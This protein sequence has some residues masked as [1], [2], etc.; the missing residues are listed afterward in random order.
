MQL[1][2][3]ELSHI[4]SY[5]SG[6]LELGPGTTLVVGDVG[7]GKTSLLYAIE[8]ALFGV[9]EV[10]ATYLIRHGAARA[11]VAVR[12]EDAE[13][14][15]EVA[16]GFRRV[17]RRGRE[18]FEPER[19]AFLEDGTRTEYSATEIRRRV[20]DLLGFPDNPSPQARSDLWRWA[21][22]VPQEQM[23]AILAARPEDRLE[24]VRKALGV[25]RFRIAADNAELLAHDLK[26]GARHRRD[27]ASQLA[28]WADELQEA[29][30]EVARLTVEKN[31]LEQRREKGAAA[32]EAARARVLALEERARAL[33]GARREAD[34]LDREQEAETRLL[35]RN[36]R[37]R[38]DRTEEL[39]RT[40]QSRDEAL[41]QA[42]DGPRWERELAQAEEE[43]TRRRAA[44]DVHGEELQR[45]AAVRA[46]AEAS[47]RLE[48]E[49]KRTCERRRVDLAEARLAL[50]ASSAEGP[51]R[52]PPAPTPRSLVDI[53]RELGERRA[54]EREGAEGS[55]P[56]RQ[57]L[58][59]VDELL[60]AGVCPTCHQPVDPAAF[61][62]H[63]TEAVRVAEAA[64]RAHLGL[65][66]GLVRLEEERKARERYERAH[67]RWKETERRRTVLREAQTRA[68]DA[69]REA[70]QAEASALAQLR[71]N[72]EAVQAFGSVA[73]DAARLRAELGAA[74]ASSAGLREK[75]ERANASAERA[76]ALETTLQALAAELGRAEQE[77][78]TVEERR[79]ERS[80]RLEAARRELLSSASV[81]QDL[82]AARADALRVEEAF[83][84][85]R[86]ALARTE[87]HLASE[88]R[89]AVTA[90]QGRTRARTLLDEAADLEA[91]A[92]WASGPFRLHVLTMERKVLARAQTVFDREFSRYFATLVDDP[93][94][95][96]RVDAGFTP[97]V[98]IDGDATP[99][100]ALS[101]GERTSLALAFRL[102]LATVVRSL[103]SVRLATLIL[104]EPTDGFSSEQ[105]VRMG[106]LLEELAIPQVIVVSHEAQLASIAD[107]VVRVRKEEGRSVLEADV[108][109]PSRGA[110]AA[111]ANDEGSRGQAVL[112]PR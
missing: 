46:A 102:A 89:R 47:E 8:M 79:A 98:A 53:D 92:Q 71:S 7:A 34:H 99:A 112:E 91:K 84:A 74:E 96:A 36:Q 29:L 14:R 17:R 22:Y 2:R 4:R 25:E 60:R 61:A 20:I 62:T 95:V 1:R 24:T 41:A 111:G 55:I 59:E 26:V 88:S 31:E 5:D 78:R 104:D 49:R 51:S 30:G 48:S 63:R 106:E 94:L 28:H 64:E 44:L 19:I 9:A 58:A 13:H 86:E 68:E 108:P 33:D 105:V 81:L 87:A 85:A 16:R 35:E 57:A 54:A 40:R 42:S 18:T 39:E 65:A 70:E 73:E 10:D 101:G 110:A 103:G 38:A 67:D 50:E 90:E 77:R 76:R 21:I 6:R 107:R 27:E 52:E 93:A 75:C 56:A 66:E 97:E 72:R 11:E 43:R 3:L 69:L 45:L 100:E 23:R 32:R 12:F 15:Y 37:L 109:G 80:L 82:E 83:A